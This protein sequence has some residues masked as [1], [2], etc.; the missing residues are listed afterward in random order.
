MFLMF[1]YLAGLFIFLA[2]T[3]I[4]TPVYL[5]NV[6]DYQYFGSGYILG[7]VSSLFTL[8]GSLWN[9]AAAS[10]VDQVIVS[11]IV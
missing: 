6:S 11:Q 4:S 9:C 2:C 5:S 8:W 1:I 10:A 3:F 7:W